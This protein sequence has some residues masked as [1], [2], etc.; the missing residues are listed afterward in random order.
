MDE[1]N[2]N[3]PSSQKVLVLLHGCIVKEQ[4][5][6]Y[7]F[8]HK[9]VEKKYQKLKNQNKPVLFIAKFL[10]SSVPSNIGDM[11]K[12][13][14]SKRKNSLRGPPKSIASSFFPK[15]SENF[16]FIEKCGLYDTLLN[17]RMAPSKTAERL[18]LNL[19]CIPVSIFSDSS[20]SMS[21]TG[22]LLEEVSDLKMR[23]KKNGWS[24]I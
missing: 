9:D 12:A 14:M 1:A 4:F 16:T 20:S 23:R 6:K 19:Q 2:S 3:C 24:L 22:K 17:P 13:S 18:T 5:Y 21:F 10:L 7:G 15:S 8:N 11:D